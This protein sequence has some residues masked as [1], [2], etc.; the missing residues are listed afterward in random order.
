MDRPTPLGAEMKFGYRELGDRSH[1]MVRKYTITEMS[2]VI[3]V[4][5]ARWFT[6][7]DLSK[8]HEDLILYRRYSPEDYPTYDNF[9]AIEVVTVEDIPLDYDG[10][11]GVP[12]TFLDK[13]NP[14]QFDIVGSFNAG[15][16]GDNLGA[17]KTEIESNGKV[18]LWNGPVVNRKPLYKRIVI[19]RRRTP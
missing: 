18:M 1:R 2:E 13:R 11:M 7:L 8:R 15:V 16:G 14:A 9:D 12:I 4:K 10:L 3:R 19:R 6:N 5:G 17:A